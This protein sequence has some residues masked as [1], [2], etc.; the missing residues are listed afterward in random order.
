MLRRIFTHHPATYSIFE[1]DRLFAV[2]NYF[3]Q[4]C[5]IQLGGYLGMVA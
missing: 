1:L 4:Q 5:E 2:V 3:F